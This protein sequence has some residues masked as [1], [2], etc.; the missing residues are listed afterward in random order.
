MRTCTGLQN[1]TGSVNQ[2]NTLN[3]ATYGQDDVWGMGLRTMARVACCA[4][5]QQLKG[6]GE[7]SH[8]HPPPN[9]TPAPEANK[10]LS[11]RGHVRH[12]CIICRS[13]PVYR[14]AAPASGPS[15]P[16]DHNAI[17]RRM[18]AVEW[19]SASLVLDM[20]IPGHRQCWTASL[21]ATCHVQSWLSS[22]MCHDVCMGP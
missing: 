13:L 5:T 8:Q 15:A 9:S 4:R 20:T 12:L 7:Y 16:H 6:P 19:Q 11:N 10:C 1:W 21:A 2:S 14:P 17:N 18:W 3:T 22:T